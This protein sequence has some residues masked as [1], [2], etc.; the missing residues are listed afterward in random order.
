MICVTCLASADVRFPRRGGEPH[1]ALIVSGK[2]NWQAE[3]L[4]EGGLKPSLVALKTAM[5]RKKT[6]E[7]LQKSRPT[8]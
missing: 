5:G 1:S 3:A 8:G 2:A 4:D 7:R 6:V